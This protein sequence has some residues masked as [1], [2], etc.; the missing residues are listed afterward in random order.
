MSKLA[1]RGGTPVITKPA[2]HYKWPIITQ[3]TREAVLK[4]LDTATSIKDCSGIIK[5]FETKFANYYGAKYALLNNS[6]TISIFAMFDAIQLMPGDEVICPDYTWFATISPVVYLG[7]IPVFCDCDEN[8]NMSSEKAKSLITERTRAIIVTHMWGMPCAMDR[9]TELADKYNLK[10]LEDC[11]HAHGA[12]YQGR[13]VGTFGDAAS[14]SLQSAKLISG[15][16][17]GVLLTDSEDIYARAQL[18][19]HYN[20]RCKQ[21]V[22]EKHVMHEFW[23]TGFGLKLRAHPLGVA[24]ANEQFNHMDKWIKQKRVY[25]RRIIDSLADIPFLKF[26]VEHNCQSSWY[27]LSIRFDSTKSNSVSRETFYDA[28]VAEGL[29]ERDIP[30]LTG[31]ISGLPLFKKLQKAMP[32]L[33]KENPY[34]ER[35]FDCSVSQGLAK[36]IITM[37]IWALPEDEEIVESYIRGIWKV[38]KAVSSG[39]L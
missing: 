8:G 9:F 19:G 10:L 21:N 16:E 30:S 25:A 27:A 22:P 15:G 11:S 4:Q 37:P 38:S 31:P 34:E 14:W 26:P 18:L 29:V 24:M 1:I 13:K 17:G 32:R 12:S 36:K 28:L 20:K 23:Q 35:I 7:A 5:E 33:Y 6:G 2:P 3:G 39:E